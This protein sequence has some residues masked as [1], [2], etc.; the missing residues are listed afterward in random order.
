[1]RV[2][3]ALQLSKMGL[4]R[5]CECLSILNVEKKRYTK[6]KKKGIIYKDS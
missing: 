2:F 6:E 4:Y 5:V 1:M 3:F